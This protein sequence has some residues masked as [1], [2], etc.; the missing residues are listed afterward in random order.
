MKKVRALCMSRNYPNDEFPRLGI[1]VE[2]LVAACAP[3]CETKVIAPVPYFPALPGPARHSRYSRYAHISQRERRHDIEVLRPRILIPPG[4][5]LHGL[6]ATGYFHGVKRQILKLRKDFEFDLIHAHF[7]YPDGVVAA[8]L[9][10]ELRVPVVITEHASWRPW[11]DDYPRVRRQALVAATR[12]ST[13]IA[14]SRSLA[15]SMRSFG[16]PNEKIAVVPNVIDQSVFTTGE[17]SAPGPRARLLFVGIMR[18]VKGLDI[19]LR[20]LRL[21]LDDGIDVEL[22]IVGESFYPTYAR[23]LGQLASLSTELNLD[24]RVTFLGGMEPV[25]VAAEMRKSTVVV[26]PSRRET[27][28]LV[29]AEALACGIPVVATRC[30]GPEDIVEGGLG[31]MVDK[32]NPAALAQGIGNVLKNYLTYDPMQLRERAL[33]R[34]GP[35][36]VS[37]RLREIY[38]IALTR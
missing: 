23:D 35:D 19:L 26:L 24:E 10:K 32:E 2:R 5:L 13:L 37:A 3:W 1:W 8:R 36:V 4:M 18:H 15:D 33:N 34:F 21:L 17:R 20:A 6:E 28:G 12:A 11:L 29:L 25:E 27:F 38:E 14:V 31:V 16:V 22:A 30:G 7:V 9:G